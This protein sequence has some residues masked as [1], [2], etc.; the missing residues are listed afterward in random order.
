MTTNSSSSWTW[1]PTGQ[2]Q[3]ITALAAPA[4]TELWLAGAGH[5][6]LHALGNGPFSAATPTAVAEL[7]G[8]DAVDANTAYVVGDDAQI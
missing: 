1:T 5:T 4:Q 6:V 8:V 3:A 2:T 7:K